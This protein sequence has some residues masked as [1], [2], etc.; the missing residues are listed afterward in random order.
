MERVNIGRL[1]V[2]ALHSTGMYEG[3]PP[4]LFPITP[5]SAE[6]NLVRQPNITLY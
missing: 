3:S 2:P 4:P 5:S 6:N 1:H